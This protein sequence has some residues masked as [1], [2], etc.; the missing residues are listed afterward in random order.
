LT[1]GTVEA[2]FTPRPD[3]RGFVGS[4]HGGVAATALDEIL[5]E[6]TQAA[7]PEALTFQ[8][9]L[10]ALLFDLEDQMCLAVARARAGLDDATQPEELGAKLSAFLEEHA[11]GLPQLWNFSAERLLAFAPDPDFP[12]AFEYLEPLA[13][14]SAQAFEVRQALG[15]YALLKQAE[16]RQ[17]RLQPLIEE[18][19]QKLEHSSLVTR[20]R[21][22]LEAMG[23]TLAAA[24]TLPALPQ[25]VSYASAEPALPQEVK[26]LFTL[27]DHALSLSLQDN[28]L[29]LQTAEQHASLELTLVVADGTLHSA[30]NSPD[31]PLLYVLDLPRGL[32]RASLHLSLDGQV[33]DLPELRFEA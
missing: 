17:A 28:T 1:D 13:E 19:L 26:T 15:E 16:E 27:P 23:E 7:A 8:Y 6:L 25:V 9:D 11:A 4:L 18:T 29:F 24:F 2:W 21:R 3:Y 22:A 32:T 5:A 33:I 10:A 31:N 14:R 12:A 20:I 30:Q